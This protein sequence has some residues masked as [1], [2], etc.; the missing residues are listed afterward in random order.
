MISQTIRTKYQI[1]VLKKRKS[2]FLKLLE[3]AIEYSDTEYLKFKIAEF[4][5]SIK[6]LKIKSMTITDK[7]LLNKLK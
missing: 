3:E 1:K 4:E 6:Q 5:N 2:D 7:K